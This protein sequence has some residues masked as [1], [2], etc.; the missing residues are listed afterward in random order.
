LKI[1]PCINSHRLVSTRINSHQLTSTRIDLHRVAS[2]CID[3]HRL[4]STRIDSH[5]IVSNRI[6]SH[7]LAS[8][9]IY[10]HR[11]AVLFKKCIWIYVYIPSLS[12]SISK[13]PLLSF[14]ISKTMLFPRLHRNITSAT[15]YKSSQ[16]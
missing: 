5:R 1:L 4:V 2:T 3:S 6:D 10:S 11:L 8:T 13:R 12:N 15:Y 9:T 14:A 7:R 16:H